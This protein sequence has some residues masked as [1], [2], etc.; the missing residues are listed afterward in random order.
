MHCKYKKLLLILSIGIALPAFMFIIKS[1]ENKGIEDFCGVEPD[2]RCSMGSIENKETEASC[3]VKL[4]NR[5]SCIA[6]E[7]GFQITF[8]SNTNKKIFSEYY[9]KEPTIHQVTEN[10]FEIRMSV[11]SPA[12]YVFYVDTDNAEVSETSFNPLLI[13][14]CS[15]AYMEDGKLT[16][17]DGFNVDS[18][19]M[20]ISRDF[21]KTANPM[22]AI[23]AIEMQGRE[24]IALSYYK[25]EDF[26]ESARCRFRRNGLLIK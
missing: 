8:Y 25:G 13:G 2:T 7:D 24:T 22:S 6:V 3:G 12:A 21:T 10:I 18:L 19:Y 1:M 4:N 14:D 16:L 15:V 23:I 11:G 26:E 9:P 5:Y 17:R 20:V